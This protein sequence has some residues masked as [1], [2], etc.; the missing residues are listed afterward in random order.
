M[1][2]AANIADIRRLESFPQNLPF[3]HCQVAPGR[4]IGSGT[5]PPVGPRLGTSG[6]TNTSHSWIRLTLSRKRT[7]PHRSRGAMRGT[8]P[9]SDMILAM[10]GLIR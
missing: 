4:T 6:H 5:L 10:S 8:C 1:T 9:W 2:A 3:I 7:A